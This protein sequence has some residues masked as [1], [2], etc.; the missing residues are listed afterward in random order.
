[1]SRYNSSEARGINALFIHGW[2]KGTIGLAG[3]LIITILTLAYAI[4]EIFQETQTKKA[5]SVF[6]KSGI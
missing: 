6:A 5:Q 2:V 3:L 4:R 1:M